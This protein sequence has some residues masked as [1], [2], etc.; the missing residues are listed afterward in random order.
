MKRWGCT[1]IFFGGKENHLTEFYDLVWMIMNWGGTGTSIVLSLSCFAL[2]ETWIRHN[3]FA[4]NENNSEPHT[5][6]VCEFIIY[7]NF[8]FV[9][10]FFLSLS[11]SF[12]TFSI[13]LKQRFFFFSFKHIDNNMQTFQ[14]TF[15]N[16]INLKFI[17]KM[18][19]HCWL[20]PLFWFD[21][22]LK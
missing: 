17:E 12:I 8:F 9:V 4:Y 19:W 18:W 13:I 1:R 21:V 7:S 5:I 14:K 15:K 3:L 20:S 2:S 6:A 10:I 22:F 16:R 11:L